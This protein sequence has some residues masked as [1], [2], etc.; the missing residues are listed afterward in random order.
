MAIGDAV[1]TASR[2]ETSNKE[3]HS[4]LVVSTEVDLSAFP[5]H[6]LTVR[7]RDEPMDVFA[8]EEARQ[9]PALEPSKGSGRVEAAVD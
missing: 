1:N 7:G 3:F 9:L 5:R 2:L 6:Q 4:P 8:I